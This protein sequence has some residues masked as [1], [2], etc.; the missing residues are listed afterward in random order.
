MNELRLRFRPTADVLQ[1]LQS[2]VNDLSGQLTGFKL[3]NLMRSVLEELNLW[4]IPSF[5]VVKRT[6]ESNSTIIMPDDCIRPLE[7]HKVQVYDGKRILLPYGRHSTLKPESTYTCVAESSI[8]P[9]SVKPLGET[10]GVLT[11]YWVWHPE[12]LESYGA[13]DTRFFGFWTYHADLLYIEVSNVKTDD[14]FIIKYHSDNDNLKKIPIDAIPMV[15]NRILQRHWA[16]SDQRTATYY[17]REFRRELLMFQKFRQSGWTIDDWADA[18]SSQYSP[19]N[20]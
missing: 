16:S 1:E 18:L 13:S 9:D 3:A 7:V 10:L 5:A 6:V 4:V 11:D 19:T 14:E 8:N 20:R 15:R 12:Y 2:E 17:L